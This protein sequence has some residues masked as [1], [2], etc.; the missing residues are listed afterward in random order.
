MPTWLIGVKV[1]ADFKSMDTCSREGPNKQGSGKIVK[2]DQRGN[3]QDKELILKIAFPGG[4]FE[5]ATYSE[6]VPVIFAA[7]LESTEAAKIKLW[8]T[9]LVSTLSSSSAS[10]AKESSVAHSH[11]VRP[12][13]DGEEEGEGGWQDTA[14]LDGIRIKSRQGT[15]AYENWIREQPGRP[16]SP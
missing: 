13:R 4:R 11:E 8:P 5:S 6:V 1:P 2:F 9:A 14:V 12:D 3:G 15:N 16:A 7:I 10:R